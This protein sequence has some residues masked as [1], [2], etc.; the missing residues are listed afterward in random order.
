M[1]RLRSSDGGSRDSE[2]S[3]PLSEDGCQPTASE[4]PLTDV[5]QE[6]GPAGTFD[7]EGGAV[8]PLGRVTS[9]DLSRDTYQQ[10]ADRQESED[11]MEFDEWSA[12]AAGAAAADLAAEVAEEMK[13]ATADAINAFMSFSDAM[14]SG[15]HKVLHG[16]SLG[17]FSPTNPARVA[18][19]KI[20]EHP[21][22]E[23]FLLLLILLNLLALAATSPGSDIDLSVI[24]VQGSLNMTGNAD[25]SDSAFDSTLYRFNA[26]CAVAFTAEG[27]ARIVVQGFVKGK[28]AYLSSPWNVFEFLLII[29]IWFWILA[30]L[31]MDLDDD[32][33]FVLSV[34][35]TLRLMRFFAGIRELMASVAQ[36]YKMLLTIVSLL[37][38]TWIIGGVVGM[39]LFAGAVSRQCLEPDAA[40]ALGLDVT[41]CPRTTRCE[42]PRLCYEA[43]PPDIQHLHVA[44]DREKHLDKMGFDTIGMSFVTEFQMTILDGW[45]LMAQAITQSDS[46][47]AA[48]AWWMMLLFVCT[49]SLLTVNLFLASVA[50]SYLT[51]RQETRGLSVEKQKKSLQQQLQEL[52]AEAKMGESAAKYAFPMHPRYTPKC[53]ELVNSSKFKGLMVNVVL[54][55]VAVMMTN[56][57]EDGTGWVEYSWV[58]WA[59]FIFCIMYT[60]EM[61]FMWGAMGLRPYLQSKL[62]IMDC[63]IVAVAWISGFIYIFVSKEEAQSLLAFRLLR[64]LRVVKLLFSNKYLAELLELAFSSARTIA[65]LITFLFFVITLVAIMGMHMFAAS[66]HE[67]QALPSASFGS[68]WRS[69][70]V[71]FQIITIDNWGGITYY[72][73]DCYGNGFV[74]T[75]FFSFVF[76]FINF[77]VINLFTAVFIENFEL[78]EE[79][80]A[81]RQ[82]HNALKQIAKQQAQE[83]GGGGV[84]DVAP[85]KLVQMKALQV[86][87]F[88]DRKTKKHV[89]QRMSKFSAATVTALKPSA[90]NLNAT[91]LLLQQNL[92]DVAPET[93]IP[94]HIEALLSELAECQG[95]ESSARLA[96]E[97]LIGQLQTL[98]EQSQQGSER[99]AHVIE[100]ENAADEHAAAQDRLI[101]AQ[102]NIVAATSE[103]EQVTGIALPVSFSL[104]GFATAM[105]NPNNAVSLARKAATETVNMATR[106]PRVTMQEAM[107]AAAE[108]ARLAQVKAIEAANEAAKASGS[109]AKLLE[110]QALAAA[111]QMV[112]T[113]KIAQQKA[114]EAEAMLEK[115]VVSTAKAARSTVNDVA[116]G[117]V[118]GSTQLVGGGLSD[119]Y[120]AADKLVGDVRSLAVNQVEYLFDVDEA[121]LMEQ[122]EEA[123]CFKMSETSVGVFEPDNRLRQMFTRLL[124]WEAELLPCCKTRSLKLSFDSFV[125]F[126]VVLSSLGLAM[127]GPPGIRHETPWL[128]DVLVV[129]DWMCFCIFAFEGFVKIVS[130]GFVL[131]PTAYLLDKYHWL[132][133]AVIASSM[134]YGI[135]K[136]L[137]VGDDSPVSSI[138]RI[139]R[140]LR[141]LKLLKH[142]PGMKVVLK[143]LGS[144]MPAVV[145]IGSCILVSFTAFGIL[146][147][148]FFGGRLYRCADD[149]SLDR[150]ACLREGYEWSNN[151]FS[152]DNIFDAYRALY[153]VW[154][155]DGWGRILYACTDAPLALEE[156]PQRGAS[157][158]PVVYAYFITFIVWC[159]FMLNGLFVAC[160]VDMFAQSSGTA[161]STAAQKEWT[162]LNLV[163]RNMKVPLDPPTTRYLCIPT[164]ARERVHRMTESQ[165]WNYLINFSIVLTTAILLLPT[166]LWPVEV[167]EWFVEMNTAVLI[168]WTLEFLLKTVAQGFLKYFATAKMDCLVI[169]LLWSADVHSIINVYAPAAIA[170]Q[171]DFLG[172]VAAF[173]FLR[174]LRLTRL[175]VRV[176]RLRSLFATIELSLPQAKNI[177]VIMSMVIFVFGV[178]AMKLFGN[179]CPPPLDDD[180]L[181]EQHNQGPGCDVINQQGT[182]RD[183]GSSMA[184]LFELMTNQDVAPIMRDIE[185]NGGADLPYFTF[186]GLFWLLANFI[187]LNLFIACVVE[188]YEL[189]VAADSF[190]MTQKDVNTM[191]EQW[192]RAGHSMKRGIHISELR[193]FIERLEGRFAKLSKIDPLWYN[194]LLIELQSEMEDEIDPDTTRV[195]FSQLVLLLC[196]MWFGPQCLEYEERQQMLQRVDQRREDFAQALIRA[197]VRQYKAAR[198]PPPPEYASTT[199][200]QWRLVTKCA[201]RLTISDLVAKYKVSCVEDVEAAKHDLQQKDIL[202]ELAELAAGEDAAALQRALSADGGSRASTTAD[203]AELQRRT[204]SLSPAIDRSSQRRFDN[205]VNSLDL[206][207]ADAEQQEQE[208]QQQR[209][210]VPVPVPE[211]EP[212]QGQEPRPE[213]EPQP[214]LEPEQRPADS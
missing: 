27:G 98:I 111:E 25:G 100:V 168:L 85:T 158:G 163:L 97:G 184:M 177:M 72:Y 57:Y 190:E 13:R 49:V 165:T 203:G 164:A 172:F 197:A 151:G 128:G 38:Y 187:L 109:A 171:F 19:Q 124:S 92:R 207:S 176:Q 1:L 87:L 46:T 205:P 3:R 22:V 125:V 130:M 135:S 174:V 126:F 89:F 189:G 83:G 214:E 9:G 182:F 143:A 169:P 61:A 122:N 74:V 153:F 138:L 154:T 104:G 144:M 149:L 5:E 198:R 12:N 69:V 113:A 159:K 136:L 139:L 65:S 102:R 32:A 50:Y 141:P 110:A 73:M 31:L 148:A 52:A 204:S 26:F 79:M 45:P 86:S 210:T 114:A 10:W 132:D 8:Q 95:I 90:S 103:I 51:V 54:L 105:A 40:A 23:A 63:A 77:V 115:G 11:H 75:M 140:V 43:Q 15:G 17:V 94:P 106:D 28:G 196:L 30:S 35:R 206:L 211:Q 88:L 179:I 84:L 101:D 62:N 39:E 131:T 82:E 21:A 133:F 188:N 166:K 191:R 147:V 178:L 4:N 175:L 152:F 167:E 29:C 48:F 18:L 117:Q 67:G 41:Q 201:M 24:D 66:C 212:E 37:L 146:G 116:H 155:G 60:V 127:E 64:V 161:L 107:H 14:S 42:L 78:S 80:K 99:D 192:D 20:I 121:T 44:Q 33:G 58:I 200:A 156:A 193:G 173:Q 180:M 7:M 185:R 186:F 181:Q 118:A 150:A 70:L 170:K 157:M 112:E 209:A 194:R 91:S 142:V 160:V 183:I 6:N 134:T 162:M 81:D 108:T 53:K 208:Q 55:N 123:V 199:P 68:F 36:G 59:E 202:A 96:S 2:L 34:L 56:E 76:V 145:G 119:G 120:G 213:P 137:G 93:T 195:P 47:N 16:N 129:I 71:I